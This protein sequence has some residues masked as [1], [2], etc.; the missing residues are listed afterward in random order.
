MRHTLASS[1]LVGGLLACLAPGGCEQHKAP[2]GGPKGPP[3][4]EVSLPVSKEIRDYEEFAGRLEAKET[5]QVRARVTGYLVKAPPEREK[6]KGS[7]KF[8]KEGGLV[9]KGD[10]L[11]EIDPLLYEAQLARAKAAVLK[12]EAAFQ[13]A[14][15]DWNRAKMLAATSGYQAI[16]R[17]EYDKFRGV[18]AVAEAEVKVARADLKIAQVNMDYC[19]V[20][21]PISG[22]ISKVAIDPGNL[23]RADDTV[24]TSI[25]DSDPIKAYFDVDERTLT[26]ILHLMETGVIPKEATGVEVEMGLADEEDRP[27]KGYVDFT[28]NFVDVSTGTLRVRGAF[29][30]H[31]ELLVPGMFVRVRLPIGQPQKARLIAEK[32]LVTDQGQKYVYVVK[33]ENSE[34][35]LIP[36]V[37]FVVQNYVY[38]VKDENSAAHE[39]KVEYR[40]V[41][42][43]RLQD[44]LRVIK[45]GLADTEKVVVSGLQRVRPD[46]Q[47]KFKDVP[48]P[49][50]APVPIPA[51]PTKPNTAANG[52]TPIFRTQPD[53]PAPGREKEH[54]SKTKG[55]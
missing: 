37:G 53:A 5:I 4:V 38:F 50:A 13:Q 42:L 9:Q 8:F 48:M 26:R 21:A 28:D 41:K 44:G 14:E 36:V 39:G 2:M 55:H 3:E 31:K 11:F 46:S 20:L 30:N 54:R 10:L 7:G 32:A 34:M 47:V 19:R 45:D 33:D 18:H 27:H 40:K 24:L 49:M 6:V 43:G 15:R 51:D 22:R 1:L 52:S 29:E 23:V 16:T 25:G 17:E 12:A 35:L